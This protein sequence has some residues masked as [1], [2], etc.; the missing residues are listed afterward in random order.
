MWNGIVRHKIRINIL[1]KPAMNICIFREMGGISL[2]KRTHV[3]L[4]RKPLFPWKQPVMLLTV[5]G[6]AGGERAMSGVAVPGG[7]IQGVAK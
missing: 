2:V 1:V 7:R 5:G 3:R 6:V 4:S